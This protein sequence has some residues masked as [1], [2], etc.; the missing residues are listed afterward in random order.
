M[1]LTSGKEEMHMDVALITGSAGL[2]GA[3]AVRF[4]A[5]L[6]L[7]DRGAGGCRRLDRF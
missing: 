7:E 2:I 1:G 5:E 6:P 4:K 3:E